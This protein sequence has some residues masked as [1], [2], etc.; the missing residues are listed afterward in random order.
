MKFRIGVMVLGT[1]LAAVILALAFGGLSSPFQRT[2]TLYVKLPSA[3]GLSAGAPVRKSGIRIGEVSKIELA[4]D[5]QVLVTLRLSANYP[6]G[7][8]ETCWLRSSLLGDT[9]LEFERTRAADGKTTT[10][11]EQ[12]SG[13]LPKHQ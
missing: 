5:D 2:Y 11:I 3:A 13:T 1:V 10:P 4:A 12:Q 9:W 6:I 8:D 7:Q